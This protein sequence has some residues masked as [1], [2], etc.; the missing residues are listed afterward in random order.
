MIGRHLSG[1]SVYIQ[2]Y[3]TS[4]S[5]DGKFLMNRD[6]P[7]VVPGFGCSYWEAKSSQ[8]PSSDLEL[9]FFRLNDTAARLPDI[10]RTDSCVLTVFTALE[11]GRG[12]IDSKKGHTFQLNSDE[13]IG[14]VN[15]KHSKEFNADVKMRHSHGQGSSDHLVCSEVF[16]LKVLVLRFHEPAFEVLKSEFGISKEQ[17]LKTFRSA[18]SVPKSLW[19]EEVLHRMIYERLIEGKENSIASKFCEAELLKEVYYA[20][21][22]HSKVS[23]AKDEQQHGR[24]SSA[25]SILNLSTQHSSP[26]LQKALR[27]IEE[28]LHNDIEVEAIARASALSP[29]SLLRLFKNHLQT[30]PLKH[31]W[32][33]RLQEARLLL[34]T[35]SYTILEVAHHARFSSGASFNKAYHAEFGEPPRAAED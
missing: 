34:L 24:V 13:W 14:F 27:F 7:F 29:S 22:K 16:L 11:A 4:Q 31:V 33:R 17:F 18:Q 3:R 8:S 26:Q 1:G 19:I 9:F 28:N 21:K 10:F 32:R 30:T 5:K 15:P 12:R 20:W 23:A 35:G 2:L 6:R 25:A